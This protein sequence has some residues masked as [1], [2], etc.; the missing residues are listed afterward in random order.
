MRIETDENDVTL[1]LDM[2]VP[3]TAQP[4][5][6]AA[7]IRARLPAG[8]TAE[9]VTYHPYLYVPEDS[10]LVRTL[11]KVYRAFTG[12]QD[13]RPLT[14]GGG[15]YARTMDNCVAFGAA[16]PGR[17]NNIHSADEFIELEALDSLI[18]IFARAIQALAGYRREG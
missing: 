14:T 6:I 7:K 5:D 3:V 17:H 1:L 13:A 11:L 15:T 9:L 18:E 2:R 8:G 12:E 4:D 10:F 16:F